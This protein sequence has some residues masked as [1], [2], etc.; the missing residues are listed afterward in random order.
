MIVRRWEAW[1]TAVGADRYEQ[2]FATVVVEK[3]KTLDGFR[4]AQM[5]RA[6]DAADDR[7]QLM[8]LTYWESLESI[9]AFT[10]D[11]VRTAIVDETAQQYLLNFD[12]TASHY[13]LEVDAVSGSVQAGR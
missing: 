11:D 7:V 2:H 1:A 8:D 13:S 12:T 3:L 4:G 5:L 9:T 6:V 10:G